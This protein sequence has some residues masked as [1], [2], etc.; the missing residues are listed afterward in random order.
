MR[1]R[2]IQLGAAVWCGFALSAVSGPGP[3]TAPVATPTTRPAPIAPPPP[4]VPP[5]P[6]KHD[7]VAMPP[8]PVAPAAPVAHVPT[9]PTPPPTTQP[10]APPQNTSHNAAPALPAGPPIA[11]PATQPGPLDEKLS[12]AIAYAVGK[13]MH[14]LLSDD[15][16][17][18]DVPAEMKGFVDGM[19]GHEPAYSRQDV[20]A[21]FAEFQAYTFQR[22]AEKQYADNPSFRKNADDNLKKSR[23]VLEQNAEMAGV[24]VRPDGVQV[25]EITPGSGRIVGN[26]KTLTVRNLRVSLADDTLVKNTEG[27]QTEKINA[28]DALPALMEAVRGMRVGTRCR[29]WLPPEK[30]YGLPGKPPVIGPNEAIEYE[31]ELSNAE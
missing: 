22:R 11:K 26:A 18:A 16:R 20:Q 19:S 31:F 13:R 1:E 14:D 24:D 25:L 21:A 6:E 15:G 12:Y 2:W 17:T 4:A 7:A 8:L 29:I 10:A 5:L 3:T 23:A 27:D 30:A 9:V 28:A